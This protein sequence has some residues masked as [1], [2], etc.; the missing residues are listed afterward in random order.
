M[1]TTSMA[2]FSNLLFAIY[3]L[4]ARNTSIVQCTY[5]MD[6]IRVRSRVRVSIRISFRVS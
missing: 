3:S 6:G 2:I 5:N 4:Y 1:S